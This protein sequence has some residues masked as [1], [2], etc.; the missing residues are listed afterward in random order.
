[1]ALQFSL[2]RSGLRSTATKIASAAVE[3]AI[4]GLGAWGPVVHVMLFAVGAVRFVPGALL[5]LT[6]GI[7]FG[8]LW[9]SLVNLAGATLGATAAF[10]IARYLAADWV[11]GKAGARLE[12]LIQ[13]VEAEGWRF[14]ALTRLVPLI[15]FNLLNYA[16]GLTHIPVTAYVLTSFVCMIPG[17][18]AYGWLG[19]AGREAAAGNVAAIR[20]GL[21]DLA[22]LAA[23]AFVPRLERRFRGD[24]N[25]RVIEVAEMLPLGGGRV[26]K[27][28]IIDARPG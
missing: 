7:L 14:V 8:P 1:L 13:G 16:L 5:G 6:G 26:K 27:I 10:L 19:H 21:I 9:G 15:P 17:A 11:R 24:A 28:A 18:L 4:R 2:V 3:G 23:V 20:Y 25:V 12:R 22:M